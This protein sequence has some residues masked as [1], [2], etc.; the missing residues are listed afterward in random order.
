VASKNATIDQIGV[1]TTLAKPFVWLYSAIIGIFLVLVWMLLVN[2][3]FMHGVWPA[4]HR[5]E[6]ATA[7]LESDLAAAPR[8][9]ADRLGDLSYAA[10]FRVSGLEGAITTA[11][12][13]G[14]KLSWADETL[15]RVFV[16]P[17]G[18][19]I[20]LVMQSARLLGVRLA[21]LLQVFLVGVVAIGA[22]L[23]DGLVQRYIRR[24]SAGRESANLYHRAKYLQI[25]G[26]LLMI[27]LYVTVPV[28]IDPRWLFS[29]LAIAA[30]LAF[31]QAKFYKKYL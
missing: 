28:A 5:L 8:P 30:L 4:G 2:L 12:T 25:V 31:L 6:I 23:A 19:E 26:G 15:I 29:W 10:I 11:T 16:A 13:P 24:E 7:I 3:W 20:A 17:Y 22:A 14:A 9:L 21:I 18:E 1:A 27:M